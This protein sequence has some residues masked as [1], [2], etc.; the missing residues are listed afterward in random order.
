MAREGLRELATGW[1][2][3]RD[4]LR[5]VMR[6]T[7]IMVGVVMIVG[8]AIPG[9]DFFDRLVRLVL[10]STSGAAIYAAG[11]FW[12]G[13]VLVG[14]IREVAGWLLRRHASNDANV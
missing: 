4:Q 3:I 10:A 14:E 9:S 13:G 8:W 12:Q 7:L 2:I 1:K 6:A 11:I 5:Q